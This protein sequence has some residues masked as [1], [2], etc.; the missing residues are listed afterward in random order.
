[1]GTWLK[2]MPRLALLRCVA[3]LAAWL[4]VSLSLVAEHYREVLTLGGSCAATATSVSS[5]PLGRGLIVL[6]VEFAIIVA[7]VRPWSYRRSWLRS[8]GAAILLYLAAAL[9]IL[10]C[11]PDDAFTRHHAAWL[12]GGVATFSFFTLWSGAAALVAVVRKHA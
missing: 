5:P 3:M 11:S 9:F 2:R 7:I 4:L 12:L 10:T 8:I 6:A 1:M